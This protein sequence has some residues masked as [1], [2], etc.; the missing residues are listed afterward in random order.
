MGL[1]AQWRLACAHTEDSTMG[2]DDGAEITE[3][4]EEDSECRHE[5]GEMVV[6]QTEPALD[7]SIVRN[8]GQDKYDE[9]AEVTPVGVAAAS[10]SLGKTAQ[11]SDQSA[12]LP[13]HVG[14]DGHHVKAKPSGSAHSPP[15]ERI[16]EEVRRIVWYFSGAL[17]VRVAVCYVRAVNKSMGKGDGPRAGRVFTGPSALA[18]AWTWSA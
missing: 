1:T 15:S 9:H 8:V 10:A 5:E 11:L 12:L 17:D 2:R 14:L 7:E 16:T 13:S 6:G 4:K 3:Q 18:N